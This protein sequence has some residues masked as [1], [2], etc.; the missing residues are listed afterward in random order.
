M[1]K[2]FN[3]R[4]YEL[5]KQVPKGKVTTYKLLAKALGTKAYR[6]V[7]NAMAK[8]PHLITVPCHRVVKSDGGIG[9]YAKGVERKIALLQEEGV[10]VTDGKIDSLESYLYTFS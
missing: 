8:N 7:G 10:N 3:E 5:L 1:S 2:T 6:A 4:C 9:G